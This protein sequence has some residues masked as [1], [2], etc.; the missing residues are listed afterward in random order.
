MA[1][2]SQYVKVTR[3]G[4]LEQARKAV[5]LNEMNA[6]VEGVIDLVLVENQDYSDAWQ[7][8]G[9]LTPLIRINDKILRVKT[10][11]GGQQ[12]MVSDEKVTDNLKD[13]I[14]YALLAPLK[15]EDN[16]HIPI[17]EAVAMCK[18][19]SDAN[20]TDITVDWKSGVAEDMKIVSETMKIALQGLPDCPFEVRIMEPES[21]TVASMSFSVVIG[22]DGKYEVKA[23]DL[24]NAAIEMFDNNLRVKWDG[25]LPKGWHSVEDAK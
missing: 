24:M 20:V 6:L 19:I 7:R 15:I 25:L 9:I 11:A 18:Q 5:N 8:Y 2:Q 14:G 23:E 13:I 12:A 16:I 3:E 1:K 22:E 4:L 10:L 21:E 17:D